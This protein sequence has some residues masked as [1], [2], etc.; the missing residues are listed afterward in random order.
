MPENAKKFKQIALQAEPIRLYGRNLMVR[1]LF[2]VFAKQNAQKIP[3]LVLSTTEGRILSFLQDDVEDEE[4]EGRQV[5]VKERRDLCPEWTEFKCNEEF[6]L[7]AP[8]DSAEA[9]GIQEMLSGVL[10]S[11]DAKRT[12]ERESSEVFRRS[13]ECHFHLR[14]R[15]EYYIRESQILG[16]LSY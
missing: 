3:L 5:S 12:A 15:G 1:D 7:L 2:R 10:E 16:R 6:L 11:V 9:A 14:Q 13:A 8:A 4:L